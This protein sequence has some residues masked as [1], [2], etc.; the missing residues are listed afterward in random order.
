MPAAPTKYPYLSWKFNKIALRFPIPKAVWPILGRKMFRPVMPQT[1]MAAA[2]H[3]SLPIPRRM[4][5]A[6]CGSA[7]HGH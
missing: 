4:A 5:G 2:H 7:S 3:A 6:D 1:D